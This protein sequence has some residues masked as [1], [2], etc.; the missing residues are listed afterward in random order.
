MDDPL[1]LV[2]EVLRRK[3]PEL[4]VAVGEH[5]LAGTALVDVEVAIAKSDSIIVKPNVPWKSVVAH[6]ITML[7]PK[8]APAMLKAAVELAFADEMPSIPMEIEA[9]NEAI[10]Q[11][12]R[13]SSKAGP[14]KITGEVAIAGYVPAEITLPGWRELRDAMAQFRQRQE[15]A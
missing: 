9:C 15:A 3:L 14:T 13:G 10:R 5:R 6:L 7:G 1:P 11:A 12:Q 2:S 4:P 8:K